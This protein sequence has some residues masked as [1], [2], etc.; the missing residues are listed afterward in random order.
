MAIWPVC[1]GWGC[2]AGARGLC[3]AI[4]GRFTQCANA[5]LIETSCQP[6]KSSMCSLCPGAGKHPQEQAF[7]PA[8]ASLRLITHRCG[9]GYGLASD[10]QEGRRWNPVTSHRSSA[11]AGENTQLQV[12][13]GSHFNGLSDSTAV[14]CVLAYGSR[15]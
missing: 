7:S 4:I 15:C 9:A 8:R 13:G 3:E 2:E 10:P 1:R 14:K 6:L 12:L 5:N 11:A